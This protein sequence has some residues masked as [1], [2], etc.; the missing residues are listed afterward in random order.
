M[1]QQCGF[2]NAK[3]V[4]GQYDRVYVAEQFA[5]YFASFIGNGV[6]GD[7]ARQLEVIANNDMTVTVTPGKAWINGWWFS[8]T[9]N[10]VETIS[11]ADGVLNRIDCVVL[12]WDNTERNMYFK[13]IKGVP[14]NSPVKPSLIRN[15]DYYD[16]A[17]CYVSVEKGISKILQKDIIDCRLDKTVC[18]IVT[19][20]IQQADTTDI[21]KQYIDYLNSFKSDK[22]TEYTEWFD[23][24]KSNVR[25]SI[26]NKDAEF[27][28]WFASL[29]N[30]LGTSPVTAVQQQVDKMNSSTVVTLTAANWSNEKPY[31]QS[32]SFP[33]VKEDDTVAMYKTH[34]KDSTQQEIETNDEMS[35]MIT[36]AT[37]Q[38]G[39][40]TFYCAIDKP[41]KDFKVRLRGIES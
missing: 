12:R 7:S 27:D 21:F 33:E 4:N 26:A 11:L 15:A 14:S 30:R 18:G 8:S 39:S 34:T 25:Q 13:V 35:A 31:S 10:H 32:V 22:T 16:L 29:K 2:F 37:V 19:G 1:A 28:A 41:N 38:N 3:L 9:E 6:F 36:S 5:A 20:V 17:L 40:V 23:S 24:V